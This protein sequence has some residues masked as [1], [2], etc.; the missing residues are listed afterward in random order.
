MVSKTFSKSEEI[1]ILGLNPT[2][3]NTSACL[4]SSKK[5]LLSFVEEERFTR[6]K[7]ASDKIPVKSIKYCLDQASIE[8]SEVNNITIGWNHL[9]YP[10]YMRQFYER[11]MSHP[12]KDDL[13]KNIEKLKLFNKSP[14]TLIK[15]I[16]IS[17]KRAGFGS[18][19]P[20]INFKNHHLS[21]VASVFCT[22]PFK[23]ALVFVIDGSGEELGTSIWECSRDK[24]PVLID[25]FDLNR[26]IS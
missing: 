7:L 14:S 9:K 17:L 22:S 15:N 13:S 2:G 12:S 26:S 5:G 4:I 11:R 10:E 21:H 8:L 24:L 25:K 18:F 6:V 3:P 20:P 23:K 19:L 16:S 1:Y